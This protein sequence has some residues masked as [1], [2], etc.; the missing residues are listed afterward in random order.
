MI[1]YGMTKTAQLAIARGLAET[2]A[3][4]RHH[5]Q[6]RAAGPDR[7]GGRGDVRRRPGAAAGSGRRRAMERE[8]FAA[9]GRPR[10]SERF[11]TPEEVAAMIVYVCSALAS[12][13]NGAAL[14]VDGGVVRAIV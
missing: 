1:H 12:A 14:R 7:V 11:A 9:R 8:F 13:T 10:S 4:H 5:R 3:G 6:Q 2:V